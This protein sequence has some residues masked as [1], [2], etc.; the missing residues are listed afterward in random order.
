MKMIKNC[1]NVNIKY[2]Q[3]YWRKFDWDKLVVSIFM[4]MMYISIDGDDIKSIRAC[5][6]FILTWMC[7]NFQR[8]HVFKCAILS[9]KY[10]Y[11]QKY[12]NIFYSLFV[13]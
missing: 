7:L 1:I 13:I 12:I 2:N 11:I 5:S 4:I 9:I 6:W 3:F 10:V 8:N